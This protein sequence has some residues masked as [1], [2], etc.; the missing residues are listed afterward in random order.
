[1]RP[2]RRQG[3]VCAMPSTERLD[4]RTLRA[5]ALAGDG[6]VV[7]LP[8]L[9]AGTLTW[10]WPHS[11]RILHEWRAWAASA[12]GVVRTGVRLLQRPGG[13]PVVAVDVALAGE[14]WG[15]GRAL[16]GLRRLEPAIDSVRLV[17]PAAVALTPAG[18][19]RGTVPIAMRFRLA[20]LP[21]AAVDAFA[22]A[23][24]PGS[25]SPL[26]AVELHRLGGA[27][28]VAALGAARGEED[29]ERVRI[30]LAHLERRL[31]PWT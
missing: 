6:T 4:L 7:A 27:H 20:T 10:S 12:D 29:G 1:M 8:S 2:G 3:I 30:A 5:A 28:R 14:P 23:V 13:P 21:A 18:V 26:L 24:G 22:A 9:V 16:A 17:P 19:P 15:A 25:A 11:H 31:A